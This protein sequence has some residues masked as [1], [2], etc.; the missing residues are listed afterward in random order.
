ME[1][2]VYLPSQNQWIAVFI[3]FQ[4]QTWQTD[5]QGNPAETSGAQA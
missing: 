2:F 1:P 4:T 5:D 3:A